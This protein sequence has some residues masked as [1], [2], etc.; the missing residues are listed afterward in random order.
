MDGENGSLNSHAEVSVSAISWSADED[1]S[2]ARWVSCGRRLGLMS[3]ASQWWIGDWLRYGH[4]RYR[5]RYVNAAKITGYESQTLMNL[6]YVS[7]IEVSRRRERLSW[8]HHAEVAALPP[9]EQDSW[10]HLAQD[11]RLSVRDLR[12]ELRRAAQ[13]ARSTVVQ[14]NADDDR[15][16]VVC[17]EC[18]YRFMA[19][20]SRNCVSNSGVD[21]ARAERESEES[22]A[23]DLATDQRKAIQDA[24]IV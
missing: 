19:E 12:A 6:A 22:D 24:P 14:R 5:H 2:F 21:A 16:V 10:L 11:K 3:R 13:P 1:L 18:G 20:F 17:P 15:H 8:S 7:R 4:E 9:E 23:R